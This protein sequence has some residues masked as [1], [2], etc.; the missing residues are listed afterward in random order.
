METNLLGLCFIY[1]ALSWLCALAKC[2]V[3]GVFCKINF[4]QQ[5]FLVIMK[6]FIWSKYVWLYT[7][8]I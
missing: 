6:L 3:Y 1:L 5:Y 2:P 7:C 8:L 4:V